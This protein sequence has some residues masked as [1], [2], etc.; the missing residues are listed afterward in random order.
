MIIYFFLLWK[1]RPKFHLH[2]SLHFVSAMPVPLFKDAQTKMHA[3][4]C[5]FPC[6]LLI[7]EDAGI[8]WGHRAD[9]HSN[10]SLLPKGDWFLTSTMSLTHDVSSVSPASFCN[11]KFIYFVLFLPLPFVSSYPAQFIHAFF[12]PADGVGTLFT[13][14][15]FLLRPM[16]YSQISFSNYTNFPDWRQF[17]RSKTFCLVKT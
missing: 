11:V 17:L 13:S 1:L 16:L 3:T 6:H 14:S 5:E 9:S 12:I 15:Y 10:Q 7:K 2:L 8:S 4:G